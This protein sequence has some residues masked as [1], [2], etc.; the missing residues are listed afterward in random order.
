MKLHGISSTQYKPVIVDALVIPWSWSCTSCKRASVTRNCNSI[1]SL[2]LL[3]LSLVHEWSVR[4]LGYLYIELTLWL[5]SWFQ[6]SFWGLSSH[7][8]IRKLT[9]YLWH[10]RTSDIMKLLTCLQN[11]VV[12]V[13][14][15]R[16]ICLTCL[17]VPM[18]V[19]ILWWMLYSCDLQFA[20]CN[21][22][23]H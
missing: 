23:S 15:G 5:D 21:L 13:S 3:N 14:Y 10:I 2:L 16:K 12:Y 19:E 1:I 17:C 18:F 4:V 20:I 22:S 6:T 8:F 7:I 9:P 11:Q